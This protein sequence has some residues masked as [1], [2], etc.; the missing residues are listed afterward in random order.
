MKILVTAVLAATVVSFASP[1]ARACKPKGDVTAKAATFK[2]VTVAEVA[3]QL[4]VAAAT[5]KPTVAVFDANTDETRTS[6]GIIP[7][8]V[9]LPSSME[10]DLALLP[11]NKATPV[12]FYCASEK[13]TASHTAAKRAITAGHS[14]VAVLPAGIKGWVAAGKAVTKPVG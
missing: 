12:V 6:T 14:D 10:Y 8:S 3:L 13:C 11:A 7:T 9:L 4:E 1:T 2:K 5:K